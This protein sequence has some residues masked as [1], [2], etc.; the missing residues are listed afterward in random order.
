MYFC[1]SLLNITFNPVNI[2]VH[3]GVDIRQVL[4][5]SGGG[6]EGDEA[7]HLKLVVCPVRF[8]HQGA[9]AVPPARVSL[10]ISLA[11]HVPRDGDLGLGGLL[12]VQL[13]ALLVHTV[14]TTLRKMEKKM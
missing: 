11:Q 12:P 13:P 7:P 8:V 3:P 5:G 14:L 10:L 6:P 2:L 1:L 9:P 4:V